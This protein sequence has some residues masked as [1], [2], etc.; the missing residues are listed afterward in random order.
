VGQANFPVLGPLKPQKHMIWCTYIG[1]TF[2]QVWTDHKL[3]N[4]TQKLQFGV[5]VT[6]KFVGQKIAT[7]CR[8][9]HIQLTVND[10]TEREPFSRYRFGRNTIN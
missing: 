1:K 3:V 4:T 2:C 8:I 9:T 6:E 5:M 7:F 10:L